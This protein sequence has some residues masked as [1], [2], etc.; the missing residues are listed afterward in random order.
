[1]GNSIKIQNPESF[2]KIDQKRIKFFRKKKMNNYLALYTFNLE[3][4]KKYYKPEDLNR[5]YEGTSLL[6]LAAHLNNEKAALFL[7]DQPGIIIKRAIKHACSHNNLKLVEKMLQFG[8]CLVVMPE[9]LLETDDIVIQKYLLIKCNFS[10]IDIV[11]EKAIHE[12]NKELTK[13]ILK[14]YEPSQD[15]IIRAV[16][17]NSINVIQLLLEKLEPCKKAL[18]T[19]K[20]IQMYN[21][22]EPWVR[23][24]IQEVAENN[25]NIEVINCI[26]LDYDVDIPKLLTKTKTFEKF[27]YI[28]DNFMEDKD[29]QEIEINLKN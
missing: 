7:L 17:K 22:L 14:K 19:I 9:D 28:T 20:T 13:S 25:E 12:D 23:E 29:F 10:N 5:R 2:H 24:H 26:L 16:L 21:I 4:F 6:D 27:K 3:T 8:N 11:A 1:M 18:Y 15:W